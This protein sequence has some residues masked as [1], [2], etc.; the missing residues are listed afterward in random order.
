LW[1]ALSPSL[2][3]HPIVQ[4]INSVATPAQIRVVGADPALDVAAVVIAPG[5]VLPGQIREGA[6]VD[7]AANYFEGDNASPGD[8]SYE[9]PTPS[10][11]FN[12]RLVAITREQ[13]FD[14]VEWRVANEIRNTL[15]RYYSA[16][17]FFPYA[18]RYGD[19]TFS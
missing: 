19:S 15:S 17:R 16:F 13:L 18:N 4:P 8:N 5:R 9:S 3:D 12:D 11:D 14:V 10:A 7:V 6:G 2:R 1:Y